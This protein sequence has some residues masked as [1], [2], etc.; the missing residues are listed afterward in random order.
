MVIVG[1]SNGTCKSCD[2]SDSGSRRKKGANSSN[3]CGLRSIKGTTAVEV[4]V[5]TIDSSWVAGI[6][7]RVVVNASMYAELGHPNL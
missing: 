5:H 6:G 2:G 7:H 4:R 3:K 1:N